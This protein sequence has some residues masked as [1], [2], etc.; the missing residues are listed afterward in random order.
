MLLEIPHFASNAGAERET[1]ILRSN[2]GETWSQHV[3]DTVEDGEI[4]Q[5]RSGY[6]R[7]EKKGIV[8]I[9]EREARERDS[10]KLNFHKS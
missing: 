10:S 5:V 8:D 4:Y 3:S 1:V 7:E 6:Q 9:Y 2:D